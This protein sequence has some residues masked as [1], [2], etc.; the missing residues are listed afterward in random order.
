MHFWKNNGFAPR[1]LLSNSIVKFCV[2]QDC[3][4][5]A[6][7][8]IFLDTA[9]LTAERKELFKPDGVNGELFSKIGR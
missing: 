6:R 1:Q 4:A 8:L 7:F 5:L 9:N 3:S 2:C